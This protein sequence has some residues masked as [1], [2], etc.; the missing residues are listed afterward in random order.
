MIWEDNGCS[1]KLGFKG[2]LESLKGSGGRKGI[3]HPASN[4]VE[5]MRSLTPS[6]DMVRRLSMRT[7]CLVA[8]NEMINDN[9]A[10]I[11]PIGLL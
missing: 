2:W 8:Y 9:G 11:E 10:N 1:R 4:G 3:K 7:L 6:S 5:M